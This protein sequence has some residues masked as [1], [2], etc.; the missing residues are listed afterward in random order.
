MKREHSTPQGVGAGEVMQ[1]KKV[2]RGATCYTSD[3]PHPQ[4][5]F[6]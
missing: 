4:K 6:W 5:G 2:I 3:V 1:T